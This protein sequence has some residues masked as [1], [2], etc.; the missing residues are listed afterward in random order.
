[1]WTIH[2]TRPNC[3]GKV[4]RQLDDEG[5]ESYCPLQRRWRRVCHKRHPVLLVRPAF[6]GYIFARPMI[7]FRLRDARPLIIGDWLAEVRDAEIERLRGVEFLVDEARKFEKKPRPKMGLAVHARRCL[8]TCKA[9]WSRPVPGIH[10]SSSR[11]AC[12]SPLH[13]ILS[14]R[15]RCSPS[16][17]NDL[18]PLEQNCEPDTW[19]TGDERR[20]ECLPMHNAA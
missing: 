13:R 10:P 4:R 20:S 2:L 6:P 16:R 1:V 17:P 5:I 3:E 12:V 14:R 9:M 19:R 8:A 15:S 11:T 18:I 7:S